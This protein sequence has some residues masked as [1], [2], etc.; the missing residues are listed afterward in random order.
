MAAAAAH[1]DLICMC[2]CAANQFLAAATCHRLPASPPLPLP[3]PLIVPLYCGCAGRQLQQIETNSRIGVRIAIEIGFTWAGLGRCK[4]HPPPSLSSPQVGT[5][6][7]ASPR[8]PNRRF[9]L[10]LCALCV[11]DYCWRRWFNAKSRQ[12]RRRW[13]RR[14]QRAVQYAA[15][16]LGVPLEQAKRRKCGKERE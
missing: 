16:W 14:Q 6:C 11:V 4:C 12:Q 3:W 5:Y 10:R 15:A 9:Y 1:V 8:H 2:T 13:Q 7:S